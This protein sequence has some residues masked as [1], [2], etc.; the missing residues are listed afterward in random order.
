MKVMSILGTR[1]E[2]I[3]MSEIIKKL[4]K[5]TKHIFV[6]TGQNYDPQ[7]SDVF[8][9]DLDL[10]RPDVQ[11]EWNGESLGRGIGTN[12]LMMEGVIK[13]YKPDAV[14]ILGDT[15]SAIAGGY[16]AKRMKIPLF[17]LE[18]GNRC[19]D[20]NVPEEINR[21]IMDHIS[22]VNMTYTQGQRLYLRDEGVAKERIFVMGS[23]MKEVFNNLMIEINTSDVLE[24][25]EIETDKYFLV[26]I[27]RD[28]NTEIPENLDVLLDTLN[29]IASTYEM[30]VI[31][32]TH[33]RMRKKLDGRKMDK[34]VKLMPPFGFI[35]YN[36]LQTHA[37]CVISDSG[38]IA[39]ESSILAFPAITIRNAH[40]RAEATDVGSILMTGVDKQSI[41]DCLKIVDTPTTIPDDYDVDNCSDRVLK[42]ILGYTP[43]VNR[44]VWHKT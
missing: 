33:P 27:H 39:E 19:F 11:L 23:P 21:R 4:D 3:K 29:E 34:R 22:D 8:Y 7:L 9:K 1:P 41:M 2:L 16:L 17:H 10:R 26:S 31:V 32:S 12:F 20:D 35:D 18:A 6:H 38:T 42:V 15:N 43:Y 25:L 24:R 30:P 40:E 13:E 37:K 44:Y 28:E 5:H 36:A 14:V